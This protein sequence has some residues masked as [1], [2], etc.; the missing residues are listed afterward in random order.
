MGR[1]LVDDN[2]AFAENLAE[3]IGDAGDTAVTVPISRLLETIRTARRNGVVHSARRP[4][5]SA[6]ST[7]RFTRGMLTSWNSPDEHS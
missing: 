5:L 7:A 1:Y 3:I 4:H 6:R 2:V